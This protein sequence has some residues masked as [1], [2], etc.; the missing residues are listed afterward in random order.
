MHDDGEE[1][2]GPDIASWSLGGA[3]SMDFKIKSKHWMAKDLTADTYNPELWVLPGSQAW[4]MRIAANA[5][6]KA[7]RIAEFETAK[8]E[9]F[10]F[11]NKDSEKRRKNGPMVL[12]LELRHG[13]IVVMHGERIQEIYEVCIRFR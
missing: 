9:L 8:V 3:A 6:Y 11:L 5:H 13:D 7:G 2:L 4:K 10:K 12:T 1:D